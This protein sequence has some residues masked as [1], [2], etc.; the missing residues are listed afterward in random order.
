[1][2]QAKT[3]CTIHSKLKVPRLQVLKH[4]SRIIRTLHLLHPAHTIRPISTIHVLV[5]SSIVHVNEFVVQSHR[6]TEICAATDETVDGVEDSG[7]VGGVGPA[8]VQVHDLR[9]GMLA[10]LCR[11]R[12]VIR[13]TSKWA[14]GT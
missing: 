1:M 14:V 3:I 11:K 6:A 4:T 2:Y 9:R 8:P 13:L 7:V 5:L 12:R 10:F